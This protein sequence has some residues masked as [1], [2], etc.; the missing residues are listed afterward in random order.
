MKLL[1]FSTLPA[2]NFIRLTVNP[3]LRANLMT[4]WTNAMRVAAVY[5][6]TSWPMVNRQYD[7]T[8]MIALLKP[9]FACG[10]YGPSPSMD[11]DSNG[12]CGRNPLPSRVILFHFPS[13]HATQSTYCEASMINL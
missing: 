9:P 7:S 2:S 12:Y 6:F 13:A 1:E 5:C 10:V 8:A 3:K 11:T 4:V